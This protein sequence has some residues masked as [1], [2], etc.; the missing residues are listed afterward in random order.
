MRSSF[1]ISVNDGHD[2]LI[3]GIRSDDRYYGVRIAGMVSSGYRIEVNNPAGNRCMI[4]MIFIRRQTKNGK[5]T[6]L[7]SSQPRSFIV[8]KHFFKVEKFSFNKYAGCFSK[9]SKEHPGIGRGNN[10]PWIIRHRAALPVTNFS[11]K[12]FP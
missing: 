5:V 6:I 2:P 8:A 3:F 7:K 12:Y 9:R 10:C 4:V 1:Y 11:L